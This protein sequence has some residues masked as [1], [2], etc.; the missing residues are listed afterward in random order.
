LFA[1]AVY[2]GE[3][4]SRPQVRPVTP[5]ADFPGV[6]ELGL[7]YQRFY[8]VPDEWDVKLRD[9]LG[10]IVIAQR[11]GDGEMLLLPDPMPLS[12]RG[13]QVAD[14]LAFA[15]RLVAEPGRSE[16]GIYMRDVATVAQETAA[17]RGEAALPW[18]W[19]LAGLSIGVAACAA[20]WLLGRRT[21]P[22]LPPEPPPPRP[23]T[24][25]VT[26]QAHAYRRA[27]AGRAALGFLAAGLRRDLAHA[28][29][30]P[31]AA[32]AGQLAEAAARRGLRPAEVES[33]L[34]RLEAT[35]DPHPRDV[36]KLAAQVAAL[37]RRIK[38]VH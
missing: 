2:K 32:P 8:A 17:V 21:G 12:N 19:R 3:Q 36:Q 9:S 37:Q 35:G 6:A 18:S 25:Y 13:L 4:L 1:S 33:V 10:P 11:R 38:R 7:T 14:N 28:T 31:P 5:T 26:A 23:L 15:L 22:I 16:L 29:G 20:F 34:T 24:E 30:L 27:G